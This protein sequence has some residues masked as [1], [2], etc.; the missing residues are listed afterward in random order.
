MVSGSSGVPGNACSS[1]SWVVKSPCRPH[2]IAE[3]I[4]R[5]S[6][7]PRRRTESPVRDPS[8]LAAVYPVR[9][10]VRRP[11][12]ST[13]ERPCRRRDSREPLTASGRANP[14]TSGYRPTVLIR[15]GSH[16]A[17]TGRERSER[18]SGTW[19]SASYPRCSSPSST[20]PKTVASSILQA[21]SEGDHNTCVVRDG[22][23]GRRSRHRRC[24]SPPSS[25][26]AREITS[27]RSAPGTELAS[28]SRTATGSP[29]RS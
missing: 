22:Q 14:G 3:Q 8:P 11:V 6:I 15:G 12:D 1:T 4:P 26:S 21:A 27:P 16:R 25:S 7:D 5:R 13:R 18:A 17:R 19:T 20:G 2:R 24:P 23:F 29:R 9:S 10:R 28:S